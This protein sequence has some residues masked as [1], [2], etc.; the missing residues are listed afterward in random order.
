M[1]PVA[2]APTPTSPDRPARASASPART[3]RPAATP[4]AS[5]STRTRSRSTGTSGAS[6]RN[7]SPS[8]RVRLATE[9]RDALAPEQLVRERRDVA[10]VDPGAD[11][12]SARRDRP[13]ARPGRAPDRREDD[14]R[15]QLLRA[16]VVRAAGPHRAQLARELAA[17]RL[18]GAREG[19]HLAAL[20]S[21]DL[22][23]DVG[24]GAEAVEARAARASPHSRSAR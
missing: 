3:P 1:R 20:V 15:V 5:R 7:S 22:G 2:A 18:T 13:R 8:A 12:G 23:E 10:H 9:R 14:R 17:L 16:A 11:D 4:P 21:G 24:G 6:A 19:V